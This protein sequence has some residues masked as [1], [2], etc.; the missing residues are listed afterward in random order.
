VEGLG[1]L[2]HQLRDSDASIQAPLPD[3][4]GGLFDGAAT[5]NRQWIGNDIEEQTSISPD[6]AADQV[7]DSA[8]D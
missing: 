8:I 2:G 3:D 5:A 7:I 4:S 6:L 1:L